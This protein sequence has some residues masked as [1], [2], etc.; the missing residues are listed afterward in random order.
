MTWSET[1]R[2]RTQLQRSSGTH[3]WGLVTAN[4]D[5]RGV[6][7]A[8][9]L[10]LHP[11]ALLGRRQVR[12]PHACSLDEQFW[13]V[14]QPPN[15]TPTCW[16]LLSS[17]A[18]SDPGT[19]VKKMPWCLIQM[20]TCFLGEAT[21]PF[22]TLAERIRLKE[23]DLCWLTGGDKEALRHRVLL[24]TDPQQGDMLRGPRHP[25][26]PTWEEDTGDRLPSL[27][28]PHQGGV[29]FMGCRVSSKVGIYSSELLAHCF[30]CA[31]SY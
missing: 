30:G 26:I 13:Q 10:L 21:Q 27:G 23:W 1:I 14:C 3:I 29:G 28:S 12:G 11:V 31:M 5:G 9:F 2:P 22:C 25:D 24:R 6:Q 19:A 4:D 15:S 18:P 16:K 20:Q 17:V 8:L 7:E